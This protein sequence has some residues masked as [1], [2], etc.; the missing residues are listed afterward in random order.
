MK[1]LFS[2]KRMI[3]AI[4]AILLVVIFAVL[5]WY[6]AIYWH[7]AILELCNLDNSCEELGSLASIYE[8]PIKKIFLFSG[9]VFSSAFL[10]LQ[11][12]R[13]KE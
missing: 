7:Q 1:K 4:V 8:L 12:L 10:L 11:A 2:N 3:I 13:N 9:I 6:K 5:Q